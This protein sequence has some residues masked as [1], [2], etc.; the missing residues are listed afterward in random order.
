MDCFS[1]VGI[2]FL[3]RYCCWEW[4]EEQEQA[5]R[6]LQQL[7]QTDCVLAYP[8]TD[9][10]YKLYTDASDYA[11]SG[12]LVQLDDD[13][14]E[15]VIQYVSH[16]L[17]ESQRK[18]CTMEKEAY[19]IVYSL[20]KL[21][22]YLWGAKFEIITDHK[23]L[24]SLFLS[25]VA[26][27]KVQRWAVLIAEFGAPI[28]YLEG[29]RNIRADMLS[30]IRPQEVDVVDTDDFI[31]PQTGTVT[32]SLPLKFDGIDKGELSAAQKNE[33]GD[34]WQQAQDP[35]NDDY[36]IQDGVLYS[37]KRPGLRQ[38]RYP[39][40]ILPKR[41]QD[42]VIERCHKQT[43]HAGIWKSFRAVLESY[44]WPGMR[45]LVKE[46]L[47]RCGVC[48]L[49]KA[50]PEHV[51][52]G[53][54]PEPLYP[55]QIV[56]MDL[57]GP[58]VRSHRGHTY[59]FTLID[60]LTG[61]ADAYPI[62]TKRGETIADILHTEYF[63]RY[64]APEILIS[65]RGTEFTNTAVENLCAASDVQHRKTTP[66]HPQSNAKV[67]RW[68][69]TLKGIIERLMAT[70][71]AG[72][73]R[74]LGPALTAYRNTVSAVTGHT[75]FQAL[76]GRQVRIPL[77]EA[78][79]QNNDGDVYADD[80]LA[81]LARTWQQ[82][83]DGLRAER[84]TNEE[85]Q[86]RKRLGKPLHVG[87]SVIVL[88]PGMRSAFK[89]RWDA[90]WQVIRSRH[91]VYWIRHLP[92]G[93]EKVL[94]RDKLR[95]VPAD[96]DWDVMP[97]KTVPEAR[98]PGTR[99]AGLTAAAMM[100]SAPVSQAPSPG[101]SRSSTPCPS[102]GPA[103]SHGEASPLA[104]S[105]APSPGSSRSTTPC[106]SLG[107]ASCQGDDDSAMGTEPPDSGGAAA[108]LP[109]TTDASCTSNGKEGHRYPRR[110][111][112]QTPYLGWEANPY[113]T[114]HGRFASLDYLP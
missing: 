94:H 83:R 13:G 86:R 97:E 57:T 4:G 6:T 61:W 75:P 9:R 105:Q 77:T 25:E 59:L 21:R 17:S 3:A 38:A 76:Y 50:Q 53:R 93:R 30:R 64:G 11:V 23:P 46:Q 109:A 104:P 39:R 29:K 54:M 92:S 2:T 110:K 33:F 65:D 48:Q 8:R 60:H 15:K 27:T 100:V 55:H 107:S 56:S 95:W 98:R 81:S 89:P 102:S 16:Q 10:P 108:L 84:E 111:R 5:F 47:Q 79:R 37:C 106:P 68:H 87:D 14:I 82:A 88:I 35:D 45:R 85:I 32:W 112:T 74:Q 67:E 72:W 19:A 99:A 90:R 12:I 43:G 34:F 31:E 101:S 70:S 7:L 73:E 22:A 44:V 24:R 20:N 66:Y 52:H 49:H 62:A 36:N 80:R 41:W 40:V 28:K 103:S 42:S 69:R 113:I 18:W 63:P 114:K 78:L 26:N 71:H 91:P 58:F 51:E 96:V 1:S